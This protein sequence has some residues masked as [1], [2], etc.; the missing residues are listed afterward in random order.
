VALVTIRGSRVLVVIAVFAVLGA[1]AGPV[2]AGPLSILLT[3]VAGG[4]VMVSEPVEGVDDT[5][6]WSVRGSGTCTGDGKGPHVLTLTGSGTSTNLGLCDGLLV[7]DLD[8]HVGL[9][10]VSNAD[11]AV[12]N[13]S[14]RWFAPITTFPI[15]TPFFVED[16]AGSTRG[17]GLLATRLGGTCPPGGSEVTNFVWTVLV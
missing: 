3:C 12:R 16:A 7:Q 15:V 10:L 6:S 9:T 17:A 4:R 13:V 1:F 11:G 14:Q 2:S 5:V 8:I